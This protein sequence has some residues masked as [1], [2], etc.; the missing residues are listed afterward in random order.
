M[1][2]PGLLLLIIKYVILA[3]SA[4]LGCRLCYNN[5]KVQKF[6]LES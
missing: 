3:I 4:G 1:V 5:Q 6:Q 2:S